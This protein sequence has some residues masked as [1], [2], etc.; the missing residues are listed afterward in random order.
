MSLIEAC[1]DESSANDELESKTLELMLNA[2]E[3]TSDIA[4][5]V[6]SGAAKTPTSNAK[7]RK[8]LKTFLI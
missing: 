6:A 1:G 3:E 4:F 8:E 5:P 7:T 2:T